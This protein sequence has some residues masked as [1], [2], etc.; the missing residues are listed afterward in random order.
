MKSIILRELLVA[1]FVIHIKVNI[2]DIDKDILLLVSNIDR[3]KYNNVCCI[4]K[5]SYGCQ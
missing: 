1:T 3:F 2:I 4:I 5:L